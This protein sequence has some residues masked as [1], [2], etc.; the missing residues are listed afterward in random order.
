MGFKSH[1]LFIKANYASIGAYILTKYFKSK[2]VTQTIEVL[3]SHLGSCLAFL[4]R[5]LEHSTLIQTIT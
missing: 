4:L 1:K 3:K 5:I 2:W